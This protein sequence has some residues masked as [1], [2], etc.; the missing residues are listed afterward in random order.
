MKVKVD[1][2]AQAN[3]LSDSTLSSLGIDR[4]NLMP[5]QT[6]LTTYTGECILCFGKCF[7]A[8]KYNG[9]IYN[10]SFFVVAGLY[11]NILGLKSAED[12]N[13]EKPL[14][15]VNK[16]DVFK[17][18]KDIFE[19]LGCM[20]GE[21]DIKICDNAVPIIYACRKVPLAIQSRLKDKL[22]EMEKKI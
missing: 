5:V 16:I 7:L 18:F 2:G 22:D 4:N 15:L 11:T 8:C 13:R 21:Y 10:L 17:E 12:K 3:I 6:K 1:T 14:N 20:K 9:K 19:G